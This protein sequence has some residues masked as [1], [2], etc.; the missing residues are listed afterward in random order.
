MSCQYVFLIFPR[1]KLEITT[2]FESFEMAGVEFVLEDYRRMS[3]LCTYTKS[4]E[5]S[6]RE[7]VGYVKGH[8]EARQIQ[9]ET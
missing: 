9:C 2:V 8:H 4:G 3:S 7:M 5:R 1:D 6:I